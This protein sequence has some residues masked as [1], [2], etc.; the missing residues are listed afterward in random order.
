MRIEYRI[1]PEV[2]LGKRLMV[3]I[4]AKEKRWEIKS[5]ELQIYLI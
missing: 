5:T 2:N 3:L 4:V 1:K